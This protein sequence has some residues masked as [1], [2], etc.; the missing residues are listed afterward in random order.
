MSNYKDVLKEY[1]FKYVESTDE[2]VKPLGFGRSIKC[3]N[4]L[5]SLFEMS[6]GKKIYYSSWIK[7][8][9][10]F[11]LIINSITDKI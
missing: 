6:Q 3:I 10:E 9:K 11:K 8:L 7:S 5:G 2:W 1:G 4:I